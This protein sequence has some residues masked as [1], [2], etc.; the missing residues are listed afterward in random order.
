MS[1]LL[2]KDLWSSLKCLFIEYKED[3][4]EEQVELAEQE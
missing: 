1:L 4:K 3:F 2:N